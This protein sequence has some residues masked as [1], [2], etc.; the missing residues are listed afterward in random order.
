MAVTGIVDPDR[1][2]ATTPA[3]AGHAAV[4][5][6]AARRR[7]AQQPAQGHR[8]G[9]RG[10][11]RVDDRAQ[12][13]RRARPP[14]PPGSARAPTSPASACWAT[15]YKMARA[16]GVTAVVDAAAV[17]YLDRCPRGAGRRV[18]LRRHPAQPRLGAPGADLSP[19]RRGR[20]AAARR[21]ADL[22]RAAARRRDPG[23][24]GDRRVRPPRR[25]RRRRPLT[26]GP[27]TQDRIGRDQP[28]ATESAPDRSLRMVGTMR[29]PLVGTWSLERLSTR[30]ASKRR[31]TR[32]ADQR[33]TPA[34]SRFLAL[35]LEARLPTGADLR[36]QARIAEPSG[37]GS[38]KVAQ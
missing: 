14:S 11:D 34:S 10:G 37:S 9:L 7:G 26:R 22:R 38:P 30:W 33:R 15:C 3:V 27:R 16:S 23:R 29:K 21:R 24:P 18:R 2:S 17:P 20:G 32:R 12:P 8:R 28:A 36:P 5:D 13:R 35:A 4:A 1:V 19:G 25:V 6:Q 31:V